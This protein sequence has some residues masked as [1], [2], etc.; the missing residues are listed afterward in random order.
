MNSYSHDDSHCHC[1][2]NTTTLQLLNSDNPLPL[3]CKDESR[4]QR[5]KFFIYGIL[6]DLFIIF[7]L[8]QG[9]LRWRKNWEC[10]CES[11][12]I[13]FSSV[14]LE[15]IRFRIMFKSVKLCLLFVGNTSMM[16]LKSSTFISFTHWFSFTEN[17]DITH[18]RLHRHHDHQKLID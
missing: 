16:N 8:L 18:G 10:L 15:N 5:R 4:Q 14:E 1:G 13:I 2:I 6:T 11:F 7:I 17:W 9:I 3:G 12:Y